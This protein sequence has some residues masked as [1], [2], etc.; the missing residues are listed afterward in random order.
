MSYELSFAPEFFYG[1]GDVP[2]EEL[3]ASDRPTSVAQALMSLSEATWAALARDVF[4][5]EPQQLDLATVLDHVL[6]TNTCRNLDPP[7]EVFL[8][9]EG[10]YTVLVY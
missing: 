9:A 10:F 5:V 2:F 4:D 7:V 3:P 8:D 6:T 1:D